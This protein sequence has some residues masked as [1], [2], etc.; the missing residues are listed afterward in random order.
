M[1]PNYNIVVTIQLYKYRNR[2]GTVGGPEGEG[3]PKRISQFN[4]SLTSNLTTFC[5]YCLVPH[6]LCLFRSL[7]SPEQCLVSCCHT[8]N[9]VKLGLNQSTRLR[10][11]AFS[12]SIPPCL[13]L[14]FP[15]ITHDL[16]NLN[17][18]PEILLYQ[19]CIS[20]SILHSR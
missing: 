4:P 3:Y 6:K 20:V 7:P 9:T 8:T 11:F 15:T 14:C 13:P 16:D 2:C 12:P 19:V 17:K 5:F 1:I 10:L 18:L